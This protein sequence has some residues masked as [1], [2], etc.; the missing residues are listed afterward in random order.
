MNF[1]VELVS[2]N[3]NAIIF[4]VV[5]LSIL[6]LLRTQRIVAKKST[7]VSNLQRDLRLLCNS[8]VNM[9]RRI[10]QLENHLQLQGKRQ[11]AMD[12]RQDQFELMEQGAYSLEKAVMLVHK[13]ASVDELVKNLSIPYAE[14]ELIAMIHRLDK[15][16]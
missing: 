7:Q 14:A 8:A 3:I 11:E 4:I 16:G 10:N 13:G 15:A 5:L 9:G 12:L 6:I 1:M 2:V